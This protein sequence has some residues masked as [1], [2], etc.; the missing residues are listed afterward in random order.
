MLSAELMG[1]Q[2]KNVPLSPLFIH[3]IFYLKLRQTRNQVVSAPQ[4][5]K[6][7]FPC[8]LIAFYNEETAGVN[9]YTLRVN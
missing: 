9:I 3:F 6:V 7:S 8:F 1:A 2:Y 5:Q 4:K